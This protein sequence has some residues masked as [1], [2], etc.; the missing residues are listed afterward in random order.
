LKALILK[1]DL[2]ISYDKVKW[3]FL[4]LILLQIGL[5]WEA[6]NWVMGCV[7]YANFAVLINGGPTEFFKASRGLR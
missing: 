3:D 4:R 1:L 7:M 5:S 2:M 6:T